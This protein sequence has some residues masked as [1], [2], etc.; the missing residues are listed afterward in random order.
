MNARTEDDQAATEALGLLAHGGRMREKGLRLLY[1]RFAGQMER[2]FLRHRVPTSDAEDLVQEV[3]IRILRGCENFRGDA[4]A[5]VWIWTIARNAM[6]DHHRSRRAEPLPTDEEEVD[7][8]LQAQPSHETPAWVRDC[9]HRQMQRF[10]VE[11]PERAEC[12]AAVVLRDWGI[13]ELSEFL[14]R[15]LSATKEYLSQCRKKLRAYLEECGEVGG[16]HG[17]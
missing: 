15:T 9:L 5:A 11:H 2:Y 12:I 4:P 16:G 14:G 13:D 17:F 1:E 6:L 8:L 7:R 10:E 3:F